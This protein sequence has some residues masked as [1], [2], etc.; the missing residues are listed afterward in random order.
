MVLTFAYRNPLTLSPV[1]CLIGVDT[2]FSKSQWEFSIDRKMHDICAHPNC[3]PLR[4][5]NEYV[6]NCDQS[7]TWHCDVQDNFGVEMENMGFP[8]ISDQ[9]TCWNA[10]QYGK[11]SMI[12][13][14]F[15]TVKIGMMNS[16]WPTMCLQDFL[17]SPLH[18]MINIAMIMKS[19]Y[20]NFLFIKGGRI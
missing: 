2:H 16:A 9:Y 12:S 3:T 20:S 17:M 19:H 14:Q 4:S 7:A 13:V 15:R 8:F 11:E 6:I 18:K 5:L 1:R 10:L